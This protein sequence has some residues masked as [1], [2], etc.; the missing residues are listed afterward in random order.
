MDLVMKK[1]NSTNLRTSP[2]VDGHTD[3]SCTVLLQLPGILLLLLGRG[4]LALSIRQLVVSLAPAQVK[5]LTASITI[6]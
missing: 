1:K 5:L 6:G 3:P 4:Q 2:P